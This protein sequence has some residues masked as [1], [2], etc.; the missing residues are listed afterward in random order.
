VVIGVVVA[1]ALIGTLIGGAAWLRLGP[2]DDDAPEF[3]PGVYVDEPTSLAIVT[4]T[5]SSRREPEGERIFDPWNLTDSDPTTA[6]I[7]GRNGDPGVGETVTLRLPGPSWVS[8]VVIWNGDQHDETSFEAQG[9]PGRV[10]VTVG[11]HGLFD[12]TLHDQDWQQE[13]VFPEPILARTI[14]LEITDVVAGTE[15]PEAALS[16]FEPYGWAARGA[17]RDR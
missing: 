2:A 16:G 12:V 1:A 3:D 14:S 10:L 8:G 17:D 15:R 9:R 11:E 4:A 6:W 5:A 13:V 7:H